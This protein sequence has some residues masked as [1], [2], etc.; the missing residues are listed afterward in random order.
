MTEFRE[1]FYL[2]IWQGRDKVVG[3]EII[4][5]EYTQTMKHAPNPTKWLFFGKWATVIVVNPNGD[6]ERSQALK[7]ATDY[8]KG[9]Y[10]VYHVDLD[11]CAYEIK[12]GLEKTPR[13]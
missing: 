1:V 12:T 6:L 8:M 5:N 4:F 2:A 9:N 3:S 11:R 10:I 7:F 13:H